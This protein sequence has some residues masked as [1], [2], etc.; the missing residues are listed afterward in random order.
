[1][2]LEIIPP[3][4]PADLTEDER[5]VLA[6][7]RKERAVAA[8]RAAS[9]RD[10]GQIGFLSIGRLVDAL[11]ALEGRRLVCRGFGPREGRFFLAPHTV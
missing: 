10:M 1:M 9:A 6:L 3:Q 7:L 8:G 2:P 4:L 11:R 5:R